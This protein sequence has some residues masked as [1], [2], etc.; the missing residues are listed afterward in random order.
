[1]NPIRIFLLLLALFSARLISAQTPGLNKSIL[2]SAE[3]QKDPAQITIRWQP[4]AGSTS[5]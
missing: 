1:M 3:I 2:L 5:F 4:V